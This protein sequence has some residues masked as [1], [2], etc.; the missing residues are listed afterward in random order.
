MYTHG[1]AADER[2]RASRMQSLRMSA[3]VGWP[4]YR[5]WAPSVG[6]VCGLRSP[7]VEAV[8][9]VEPVCVWRSCLRVE[10]AFTPSSSH[11][12]SLPDVVCVCA[13]VR[14]CVRAASPQPA[15]HTDGLY[16]WS[17]LGGATEPPS[18]CVCVCVCL[19]D[20]AVCVGRLGCPLLYKV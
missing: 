9:A 20:K 6:P 19:G 4:R 13:C 16:G 10:A 2:L 11:A 7:V 12:P 15:A 1:S 17:P 14:V 8:E 18:E 3:R 5:L